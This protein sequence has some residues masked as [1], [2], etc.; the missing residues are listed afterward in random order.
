MENFGIGEKKYA[1]PRETLHSI[2]I[3]FNSPLELVSPPTA[4]RDQFI[5]YIIII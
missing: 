1:V 4:H 2:Y 5:L 3:Y